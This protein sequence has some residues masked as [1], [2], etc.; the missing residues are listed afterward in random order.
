MASLIRYAEHVG[1]DRWKGVTWG[2]LPLHTSGIIACT[3]HL[4][5]NDP[6]I[7]WCVALQAGMTCVGNT[8]LALACLRLALASGWTWQLGLEELAD[9]LA[10]LSAALSQ[11]VGHLLVHELHQNLITLLLDHC[12]LLLLLLQIR[13]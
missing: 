1:K 7:S 4:F 9:T 5:Y 6:A 13:R 8:T 3:Y 2:M 11:P 10:F 12:C